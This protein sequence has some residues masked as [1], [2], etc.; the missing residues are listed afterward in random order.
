MNFTADFETAVWLPDESFVW[1]WAV[2]EIGNEENIKIGNSIEEFFENIEYEKNSKYYFHNLKFDGQFI[3]NYLLEQGFTHIEDRRKRKDKTFS[4]LISDMGM[5]YEIEV[6]FKVYRNKCKKVTFID[7]YK[8]IP[9]SVDDISNAFG[10]PIN[11]LKIDY[12]RF[13]EKEHILTLTEKKYIRNDVKI[14][15]MAL[16][17][18]FNENLVRMTSAGNALYDYKEITG[19]SKFE[20]L[21]PCLPYS[22]DEDLRPA[23]KGGFTYLNPIYKEVDVKEGVVL[24]VNSLYP[25]VLHDELMPIG[26]PEFFKGKYEYDPVYPL[27]IQRI[28]V[29]FKVKKDH[30]PTVQIKHTASF[31]DNEY[32]TDSGKEIVILT[33]CKPDLEL[34]LEQYDVTYINYESGWKFKGMRGLFTEYIDKWTEVKIK[35]TKEKNKGMRT[36]AKLMLNSLY[37]KFA[38]SKKVQS[39]I[40]YLEDEIVRYRLGEEEEAKG[41]YLPVG[42]FKTAGTL[43]VWKYT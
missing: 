31:L 43:F 4:T 13:R 6:Y 21:F 7:S 2:C 22:L 28:G 40:P 17:V 9:F 30:I 36:L 37:G 19:K 27:Y 8:I 29:K 20:D 26:M 10:L 5:F 16:N 25:S 11:K 42:I 41:L 3:I 18:L 33:L 14:V 34:F 12:K 32:I 15:A 24:D 1:A 38:T 35:A 39:K 23:Y